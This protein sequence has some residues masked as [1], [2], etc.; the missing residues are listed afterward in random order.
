MGS[1]RLTFSTLSITKRRWTQWVL[2]QLQLCEW[3]E[4]EGGGREKRGEMEEREGKR[5]GREEKGK[6]EERGRGVSED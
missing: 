4:G 2:L 5:G 3:E 1:F 6:G